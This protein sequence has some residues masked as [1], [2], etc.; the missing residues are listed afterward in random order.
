MAFSSPK[1]ILLIEQSISDGQL[2]AE[3]LSQLGFS[4]TILRFHSIKKL[5]TEVTR[6]FTG[7]HPDKI[8]I[9]HRPHTLDALTILPLVK[10]RAVPT[11]VMSNY[12]YGEWEALCIKAGALACL[13]WPEKPNQLKALLSREFLGQDQIV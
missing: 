8:V 3:V 9:S 6:Y 11:Y 7:H 13:Q 5:N 4:P 12:C 10:A 1:Q 2:L